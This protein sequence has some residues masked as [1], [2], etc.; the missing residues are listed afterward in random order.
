MLRINISKHMKKILLT[1]IVSILVSIS[2]Y[3]VMYFTTLNQ[4]EKEISNKLYLIGKEQRDSIERLINEVKDEIS[5][6]SNLSGI[7]EMNSEE[8]VRISSYLMATK[9]RYKNLVIM[10]KK[11]NVVYG[12]IEKP[13]L[14]YESSSFE[15]AIATKNIVSNVKKASKEYNIEVFCPIYSRNNSPVGMIFVNMTMNEAVKIL[16]S[17]KSDEGTESYIVNKEGVMLTES[18]S[19]PDAIG[20]VKVNLNALKLSVDYSETNTYEDYSGTRVFGRY[21]PIEGT[22]LTL[23][24]ENDYIYSQMKQEKSKIIGQITVGLQGVF[25]FFIQVYCRKKFK[26]DEFEEDVFKASE[27]GDRG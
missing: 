11:G 1:T 4:Y 21:F 3:L 2:S 10:N 12:Y 25:V 14:I 17:I 16:S 15:K 7:Q 20:K 6:I 26:L 8:I 18:K 27:E 13:E 9:D 5:F 24:I 23:I 22:E 19:I